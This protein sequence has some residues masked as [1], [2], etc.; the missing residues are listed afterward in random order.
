MQI[1]M[2]TM[3]NLTVASWDS[4][5]KKLPSCRVATPCGVVVDKCYNDIGFNH[6]IGLL[7]C[8]RPM[9]AT[10]FGRGVHCDHVK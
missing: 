6:W 9:L 1:G 3:L 4:P 10:T 8:K 7:L 2:N 5:P